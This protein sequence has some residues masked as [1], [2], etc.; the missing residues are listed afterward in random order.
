MDLHIQTEERRERERERE[1]KKDRVRGIQI[2]QEKVEKIRVIG[3][4]HIDIDNHFHFPNSFLV[5]NLLL[6]AT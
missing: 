3:N 2:G 1:R 5:Q 4:K 6:P